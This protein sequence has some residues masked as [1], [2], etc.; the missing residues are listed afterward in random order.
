MIRSNPPNLGK[1]VRKAEGWS[2]TTYAQQTSDSI[3]WDEHRSW[4]TYTAENGGGLKIVLERETRK[5]RAMGKPP[6]KEIYRARVVCGVK[7]LIDK[8]EERPLL[9]IEGDQ[10]EVPPELRPY[11]ESVVRRLYDSVKSKVRS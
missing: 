2:R 7:V 5:I 8:E 11:G 3:E 4:V 6:G 1:L 10:F 9:W